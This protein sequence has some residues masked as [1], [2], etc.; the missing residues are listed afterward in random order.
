MKNKTAII[1]ISVR[2]LIEFVLRS[3]DIDSSFRSMN[4][5]LAG[6]RAHQKVQKSK[7]DNY[8]PEV[9]LS[10]EVEHDGLT[11]IVEGRA[12]GIILNEG[13]VTIDEIKSTTLPLELIE[14]NF[15]PLHWAQA[16]CYAYFYS[17]QNDLYEI[18]VQLTYFHIDSEK[19]KNFA[20]TFSLDELELFFNDLLDKYNVWAHFTQEWISKRNLSIEKLDFPFPVY[21]KGQRDFAVAVYKTIT[22][23]KKLFVQAP[24]GTGKTISTLFP[25]VK[26]MGKGYT[27]KIFYLTA[28]TVTRQVAEESIALMCNKGFELKNITLTAKEKICFTAEKICNPDHCQYAKGHFDRVNDAILDVLKNENQLT[29]S[30]IEFYSKA[31]QVCPFEFALDLAIWSDIVVCDYNYAFDPQVYLKRFFDETDKDYIFLIDEAHN[32]VDRGREMFSG[33]LFKTPFLHLKGMMKD[34]NIKISNA[35]G[36]IN[37]FM[38]EQR[39]KC[40]DENYHLALKEPTEFYPLLRKFISESEDWLAK[41]DKT[42]GHTELLQL[43]FDVMAFLR[44]SELYDESFITYIESNYKDTTIKLYCVDPSTLLSKAFMRAKAAILFSAT[45]MPLKYFREILGGKEEDY[46]LQLPSPFHKENLGLY[47]IK[48]I[49]TK[50]KNR[51]ASYRD[52]VDYIHTSVNAQNG[53]YLVFFPSYE[54]MNNTHSIFTEK[55]PGISTAMQ[56]PNMSEEER[57]DFLAQFKPNVDKQFI[58]F[59]VMGGIF[60]EGIDLK[61]SRLTGSIIVGVGLPQICLERNII[62]DYF[63]N[64]NGKGYEYSYMF[65]GMNKV[66]QAAGRVIRTETDT[67]TV[68]L[69]DERFAYS[70]YKQLFPKEWSHYKEIGSIET[71]KKEIEDF[72]TK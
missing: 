51:E 50:Y 52:I 34:K 32:L 67:G 36:K 24:T 31:H 53:N 58:A 17:I 42:E 54:Y 16:M 10:Y 14:E 9:F 27:E 6:T 8:K 12:D 38:I 72:W 46:M 55:F 57:E 63:I 47:V 21:R 30:V 35:L 19:I 43:Y 44:I 60:S 20:K 68:V 11:Y 64:K 40:I 15:N 61:G 13:Q 45:L 22:S 65:P 66:L 7:G 59:A 48:D 3:G 39:K 1:K 25:S 62:K 33:Q 18:N 26:A 2:N 41:N 37:T 28:K 5:A 23:N 49:S 71:F 70:S 4:R 56:L 29:R 69:I